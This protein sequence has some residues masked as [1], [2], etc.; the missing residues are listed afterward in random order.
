MIRSYFLPSFGLRHR[1]GPNVRSFVILLHFLDFFVYLIP[2][3]LHRIHLVSPLHLFIPAIT[4][5][6]WP[7]TLS[8]A[9]IPDGS[10]VGCL[11]LDRDP[12]QQ[13]ASLS[14]QVYHLQALHAPSHYPAAS[15][16]AHSSALCLLDELFWFVLHC[17]GFHNVACRF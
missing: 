17:A 11:G 8:R 12:P 4:F 5:F 9:H 10:L 3:S 15:R 6:L 1:C 16:D 13:V 14:G 7:L 2:T